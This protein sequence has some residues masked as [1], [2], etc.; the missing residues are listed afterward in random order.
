MNK[1]LNFRCYEANSEKHYLVFEDLIAHGYQNA[2]RQIGLTVDN[3]KSTFLILAKW[4]ATTA[5]LMQT[6]C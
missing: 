4:H 5:I 2:D 1:Q 3:F 6:V